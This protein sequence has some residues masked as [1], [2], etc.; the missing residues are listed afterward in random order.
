MYGPSEWPEV[1]IEKSQKMSIFIKQIQK[2][3]SGIFE[4]PPL[5]P[6]IRRR[7]DS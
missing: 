1:K 5:V 7:L 4:S 3:T 2:S 6:H